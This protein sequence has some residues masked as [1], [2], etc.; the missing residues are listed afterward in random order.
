[1]KQKSAIGFL[2]ALTSAIRHGSVPWLGRSTRLSSTRACCSY[3]I[4]TR[5]IFYPC[6]VK[7]KV[8][9][10]VFQD[11]ADGHRVAHGIGIGPVGVFLDV[12]L[13][14]E[15]LYEAWVVCVRA[16]DFP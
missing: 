3:E 11:F 5:L 16:E 13:Q 1:M 9:L 14:K 4:R 15:R 8:P 10:V 7:I 6:Y 2:F 12:A